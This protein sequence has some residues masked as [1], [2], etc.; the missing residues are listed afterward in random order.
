MS[1]RVFFKTSR[2]NIEAQGDALGADSI[3]CYL[4]GLKLR[5]RP[6]EEPPSPALA[7]GMHACWSEVLLF[8]RPR[9]CLRSASAFLSPPSGLY[10]S[11]PSR[12]ESS[13]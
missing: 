10:K 4:L 7:V 2:V 11:V 8:M 3:V 13:R 6:R 9:C 12:I 5:R 1:S